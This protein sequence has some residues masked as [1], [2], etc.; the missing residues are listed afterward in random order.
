M[1]HRRGV[2]GD[3]FRAP[4]Y[5][6]PWDLAGE[7]VGVCFAQRWHPPHLHVGTHSHTPPHI[8][9]HVRSLK[10]TLNTGGGLPVRST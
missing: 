3:M 2:Q 5:M 7:H 4:A 8:A 1:H 6:W 9:C 10:P